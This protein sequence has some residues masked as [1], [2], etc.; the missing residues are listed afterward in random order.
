MGARRG[1]VFAHDGEK[2][3]GTFCLASSSRTVVSHP[4][5]EDNGDGSS[6]DGCVAKTRD[7]SSSSSSLSSQ[8]AIGRRA[9]LVAA[10]GALSLSSSCGD[11]VV[12]A[13]ERGEGLV[14]VGESEKAETPVLVNAVNVD[15][16]APFAAATEQAAAGDNAVDD[17]WEG[18]YVKP[19][20]T[21]PQYLEKVRAHQLAFFFFLLPCTSSSFSWQSFV[22]SIAL[23]HSR[24]HLFTHTH[25]SP[26]RDGAR[27]SLRRAARPGGRS[28]VQPAGQ[29]SGHCA[30]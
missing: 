22:F 5:D 4:G 29:R 24:T 13:E 12:A 26:D 11:R 18:S 27:G 25:T 19:A 20:L 15:D 8:T 17:P 30:V 2:R 7:S 16:D 9:A 21:V 3:R 10:V 28:Q 23:G 14:G 6:S 1:A